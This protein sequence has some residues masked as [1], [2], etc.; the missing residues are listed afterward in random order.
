VLKKGQVK[1]SAAQNLFMVVL[2]FLFW[3]VL[4]WM[5]CEESAL[6]HEWIFLKYVLRM[7]VENSA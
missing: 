3:C 4:G 2:S 7:G 5:D 6:L 1:M